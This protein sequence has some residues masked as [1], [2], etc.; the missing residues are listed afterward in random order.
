MT[1]DTRSRTAS[2]LTRWAKYTRLEAH[3]LL[4][5]LASFTAQ[6]GQ[7]GL[8]GIVPIR[9]RPGDYTFFVTYGQSQGE[10]SF[11]EGITEDGVLSWQSQPRQSLDSPQIQEFIHHD[12]LTN[13]IYLFLRTQMRGPYTY[14]GRLKY[15]THDA[16]RQNPVYFQWQILDWDPQPASR[17]AIGLKTTPSSVAPIESP[18]DAE[19][20]LET[21]PPEARPAMGTSTASFKSRK[22]ADRA[23]QDAR[24]TKLGLSGELLVLEHEKERLVAAGRADLA[25]LIRHVAKE[26]GDGAGFDVHSFRDDGSDLFIEVK[27]TRDSSATQ[28]FLTANELAFS[29][30]HSEQFELWR[31]YEFRDP[32]SAEF[33]KIKGNVANQLRLTATNF[34]ASLAP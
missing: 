13:S 10:H 8:Q 31:L 33:Y 7:W 16:E 6:R 11:D 3:D 29:A 32:S 2:S 5:P 34:R 22:M 30:T 23:E 15:L 28:F 18:S 26:E 19:G 1:I 17:N 9:G 12:E 14:L 24:N 27:T 25:E 20:L 4:A 21:D